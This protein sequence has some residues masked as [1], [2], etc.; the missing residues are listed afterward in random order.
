MRK[1][2]VAMVMALAASFVIPATVMAEEGDAPAKKGKAAKKKGDVK[3]APA[4]KA[5]KKAK[6]DEG[7]AE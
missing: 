1:L 6:G 4:K 3:K 2:L 5:G 7:G